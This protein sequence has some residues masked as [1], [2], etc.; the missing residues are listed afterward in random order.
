[1]DRNVPLMKLLIKANSEEEVERI[2]NSYD[3]LNN[4]ERW[5]PY[6]GI[7]SNFSQINNQ[8][9]SP[10]QALIEKPINSIDAILIKEAKLKGIDV[11]SKE[12]PQSIKEAVE[13][14]FNIKEVDFSLLSSKKRR[15]LSESIQVIIEGGKEY[16]N[17]IIYDDGEGQSPEN[18]SDTFLSL[19]KENKLKIRFDQGQ[20]NMGGSGVLPYCGK[21]K[22]QLILSRKC[23]ELLN[24]K[25]DL[26]GFTLVRLH[27]VTE[28]GKYK[29]SW[30]EYCV[31]EEGKIFSFPYEGEL[32]LG[33]H[34]RKF[35][36][37]TYIKL[38]NYDLPKGI[39]STAYKY[40]WGE[41][42]KYLFSPAL[43]I[44][45]YE[46]RDFTTPDSRPLIG[47][48]NRFHEGKKLTDLSFSMHITF[49]SVS[50]SAEV[51]VFKSI[52]K[53]NKIIKEERSYTDPKLSVIFTIN[54]QVHGSLN[55]NF[56]NSIAK[57]PYLSD[58]LVVNIDCTKMPPHMRNELFMSSRDRMRESESCDK[59]KEEIA[60]E[61][62]ENDELQALN[63]KR[64]DEI[65][66]KTR[67]DDS[68]IEKLAKKLIKED[69]EL[70]K[71]FG[72]NGKIRSDVNNTRKNPLEDEKGKLKL[73]R[74]PTFLKFK[75][76]DKG[77]IKTIPQNGEGKLILETDVENEFLI[78]AE[79]KGDLLISFDKLYIG[80]EEIEN[81]VEEF[82]D[83]NFV[84]PCQGQIKLRIK[85]KNPLPVG[86]EIPLNIKLSSIDGEHELTAYIKII[87]PIEKDDEKKKR[88][89][90]QKIS[91]PRIIEVYKKEK[92]DELGESIK[93]TWEHYKWDEENICQIF[94][95]S[96]EKM[97]V[98]AIAI[99]MDSRVLHSY[100][101][102]KKLT[103][104]QVNN[105]KEEFKKRIYFDTLMLYYQV[106]SWDSV[107]NKEDLIAHL[108]KG[109]AQN[110]LPLYEEIISFIGK[111]VGVEG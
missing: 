85:T 53:N 95:S 65:I 27:K 92:G 67:H 11:E 34:N 58:Y 4:N 9:S 74:F 90:K 78:R 59:L 60:R 55:K 88:E 10:I 38:Y 22:Y 64:R 13:K 17:I 105:L 93:N 12:S 99:N 6:G 21:N 29:N 98:D 18:F 45:I 108:M 7:H 75:H 40:L 76:M 66:S 73:K 61:L 44:L 47:N 57:L 63:D 5:L 46:K 28:T 102:R 107:E 33:L 42:S 56:I 83:V 82:F 54:G 80:E 35:S 51:Y 104:K 14:F 20:Y 26:Y 91:L 100:T 62:R 77:N 24:G 37:G 43:P 103:E 86:S 23:P 48:R 31:D 49:N 81:K 89:D 68:S 106:S 30:Y 110:I 39:K 87:E 19:G 3:F 84:G 25:S 2:V 70:I 79:D 101:N 8:Q 69:N 36:F 50:L 1:M 41:F 71:I 109:N 94:P 97:L 72:V 15:E 52:I 96:K 32:D 111:E 16:P